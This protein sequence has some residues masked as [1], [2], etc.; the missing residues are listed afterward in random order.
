MQLLLTF[1]GNRDPFP[2]AS[3]LKD[4][5]H[6]KMVTTKL[7]DDGYE[8]ILVMH[9]YGGVCG[10][11]STV[12]VS[13]AESKAIGK[14][15]GVIHLVYISSPVPEIGGSIMT[16]MGKNM[17]ASFHGIRG[18]KGTMKM[19][20]SIFNVLYREITLLASL[21]AARALISRICPTP[22]RFSMQNI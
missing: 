3:M 16:M 20:M 14:P 15:G 21:T 22:N 7:A 10:I 9:S 17:H 5:E 13:K 19:K 4:A 8:I 6:I 2:A 18:K 1:V 11:E 12:G